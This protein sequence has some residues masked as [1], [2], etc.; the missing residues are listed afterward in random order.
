M[1]GWYNYARFGSILETGHRYQF[2]GLALPAD[3]R[4]VTSLRYLLPNLFSVLA[5]LPLFALK[6][7]FV[8]VP[9]VKEGTLPGFIPLPEAYYYTE[10]VASLLILVPVIGLAALVAFGWFYLIFHGV[11]FSRQGVDSE[12][13]AWLRWLITWLG[14]AA[15]LELLVLLVFIS[16]SL[17]YL[18][19]LTPIWILLA[20]LLFTR[21]WSH[22]S[23]RHWQRI[24][25]I[26]WV[27]A[28]GLTVLFGLLIGLTG[29]AG[30]FREMNPELYQ[31]L[32]EL[33]R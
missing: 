30:A 15:L 13:M 32:V 19:D 6:S 17:R 25:T 12:S 29:Y 22:L 1:I 28:G 10:P 26:A 24:F 21:V 20:T 31:N 9:W 14:G 18:A 3:Y 11:L 5:R 33:F 4:L 16:A 27:A 8:G 7:P 2:T 23:G